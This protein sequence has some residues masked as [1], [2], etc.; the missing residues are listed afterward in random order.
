[1]GAMKKT[2]LVKKAGTLLTQAV[3]RPEPGVA[4]RQVTRGQTPAD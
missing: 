4:V 2:R 1:M 3:S